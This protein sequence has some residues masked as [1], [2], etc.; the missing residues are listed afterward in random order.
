MK[1]CRNPIQSSCL[2]LIL[3]IWGCTNPQKQ[4]KISQ[5]SIG[6]IET[7]LMRGGNIWSLD[8][9]PNGK[10]L[11][12]GNAQGF[13]RIYDVRDL[14]LT[15][16]LF[17]FNA[18]INGISWSPDGNKIA[19]SGGNEDPKVI[20]WDLENKSRIILDA[21]NRQVRS[22]RWSPKG[23]YLASTSHDGT[24]RI[25][26]P[27]G[28]PV[29]LFT[30]ANGGCVGIDW[31][32]EDKIASSCWDNTIRIYTISDTDS[33]IIENGSHRRKAVLS[34]DWHP[35]GKLLASGDYGNNEDSTHAVKIW[36][37]KGQLQTEMTA[38]QKEIRALSWNRKGN[39]LATGGESVRLWK[40][41]GTLFKIFD[42]NT[43]PVWSLDW[44]MDDTQIA[45]GHNDGKIRIWNTNGK[46]LKLLN[47]HSAEIRT[48]SF[49]K[50][51]TQ[52]LV[53]FADGK[54]GLYD[55][56]ELSSV[57]ISA[58]ARGIRK[59]AWSPD[60]N[61]FA[62][63]SNDGTYSIWNISNNNLV[64]IGAYFGKDI[65]VENIEWKPDGKEI[66]YLDNNSQLSVW[67]IN[68][69]SQ[70]TT[71]LDDQEVNAI[72]WK[73]GKPI[74]M[75][76]TKLKHHD[77]IFIKKNH[78][79][80][81]FIPLNENRFALI[82]SLGNLVHGNQNDFVRLIKDENGFVEIHQIEN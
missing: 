9:S 60:Q 69:V 40:E 14:S 41:E 54:I 32:N 63:G 73:N 27:E 71:N 36:S 38:N 23:T 62:T 75:K 37:E 11:A 17:G 51:S 29:K 6:E 49:N 77:K 79:N 35:D 44:N 80:I 16:I 15:N 81:E 56:K 59:I 50:D 3:L 19:A 64:Q 5:T 53:G 22:V 1:Q 2:L 33:L 58:H 65:Y 61:Y 24:I 30:G 31:L 20:I 55:F 66:A 72:T 18:T 52:L 26:T 46:L 67:S 43:S 7:K 74:G 34:I 25:W 57:T 42:S 47:G 76:Q 12:S 10:Y 82:D 78:E 48:N 39:F 8:W 21:H 13:L 45:S 4:E 68:G 70:F 28:K